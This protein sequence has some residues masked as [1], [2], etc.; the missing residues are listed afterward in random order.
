M[1][2]PES[3]PDV[4]AGLGLVSEFAPTLETGAAL[5]PEPGAEFESLPELPPLEPGA[6]VGLEPTAPAE[7][8]GQMT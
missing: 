7:V 3:A 5:E 8:D 1:S 6:C 4:E 2:V